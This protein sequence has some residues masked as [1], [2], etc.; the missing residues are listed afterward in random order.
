[1]FWLNFAVYELWLWFLRKRLCTLRT[2]SKYYAKIYISTY[3]FVNSIYNLKYIQIWYVNIASLYRSYIESVFQY[4]ISLISIIR[5]I[6]EYVSTGAWLQQN[7]GEK[8]SNGRRVSGGGEYLGEYLW[9][10]GIT[11][12]KSYKLILKNVLRLLHEKQ[13]S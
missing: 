7:C 11:L 2:L 8:I 13:S 9:L 1:M 5:F 10:S 4:G 6:C 12:F 3:W